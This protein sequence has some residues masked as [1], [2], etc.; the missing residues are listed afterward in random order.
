MTRKRTII[1]GGLLAFSV[2]L[3]GCTKKKPPVPAQQA[4]APTITDTNV[5]STIPEVPV[6]EPTAEP[7]TNASAPPVAKKPKP[8]RKIE[9]K[10]NPLSTQP[11]SG[12][13]VIVEEGGKQPDPPQP[14]LIASEDNSQATQQRQNTNQLLS[15][16][17]YNIN[18]LHR[19]LSADDQA[20]IQHIR[21]F[22]DQSRQA[23]KDGDTA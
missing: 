3:S 5:P 19:N 23:L 22:I 16:A 4:Q 9:A 6:P 8:P 7:T 17:E 18:N 15:A 1:V 13:K 21:G 14:P 12:D 20:I 2:V 10:K 11:P